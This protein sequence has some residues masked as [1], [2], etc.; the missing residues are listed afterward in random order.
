MP[1][2]TRK[3]IA[4]QLQNGV[5]IDKIM[6]KIRSNTCSTIKRD[7][8]ITRMDIHN[9]RR[10]Y[11]IECIEKSKNDLTS[12]QAWV[13]E[14][15]TLEYNPITIFKVQGQKQNDE[16]DNL[17]LGDFVLGIQTKF[18]AEMLQKFSKKGVCFDTT[19]K[20][21]QYD[22]P[23]LTLMIIDEFGEG[24]PVGW[25]VSNR[26]DCLVIVEFLES[27]KIR[28][29]VLQ[30]DYF[31]SDDAEQF[32]NAWQGVFG[33][34]SSTRKL[35]CTWHVDRS[36]RK[37]LNELVAI[38]AER[39]TIYHHLR[40]LLECNNIPDFQVLMQNFVS[41]LI[42]QGYTDFC[43]Y[44]QTYYCKRVIEWAFCYRGGSPLNTNM[45]VES[46]HRLLKVVY[47]Q[48]KQNRRVDRL[49]NT[50]LTIAKDKAYE[51]LI[52]IEK[53]KST[54]RVCE[55][56]KRHKTAEALLQDSG[57]KLP[58][59]DT[60]ASWKVYGSKGNE[61][62]VD[63]MVENCDCRVLCRSCNTCTHMYKC[64]CADYLVHNTVCKHI[65]IVKIVNKNI[66]NVLEGTTTNDL[67][68]VNNAGIDD[69]NYLLQLVTGNEKQ[70]P[71]P[72]DYGKLTKAKNEMGNLINELKSLTESCTNTEAITSAMVHARAAIN[73]VKI[74]QHNKTDVLQQTKRYAPNT[75]NETQLRFYS[76]KKKHKT[77]LK[78][79]AKPNNEEISECKKVLLEKSDHAILVCGVCFKEDDGSSSQI[80]HWLQCDNCSLWL[81]KNC[82]DT[83]NLKDNNTFIC[84]YC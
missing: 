83:N 35:L 9:V 48:N 14:L 5:S 21:N 47:L 62:K 77:S 67:S 50:L 27:L 74:L 8:L 42:D 53:G 31:M 13:A 32:F 1:E 54:H 55:L 57:Y 69:S 25:M 41:W 15:E 33:K 46:F 38:Q 22:F 66:Q 59:K 12:V 11:N 18:Q 3:E 51:R 56:N 2:E 39:I 70:K 6:D 76:T 37:S 10:A 45:F 68:E 72:S 60:S 49:L 44:F 28:V 52:K 40:T 43:N 78:R 79:I 84:K 61:Y 30:I 58:I 26:E 64:T 71:D 75:K 19:H 36:W 20:T 4:I 65:H 7:H 23:L 81:H 63:K 29:G 16:M 34:C 17:A 24:I 82:A 73:L 80:V